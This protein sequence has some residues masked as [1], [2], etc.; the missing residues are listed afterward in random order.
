MNR[1][2]LGLKI[3][4]LGMMGMVITTGGQANDAQR[5]IIPPTYQAVAAK[6]QTPATLLYSIAQLHSGSVLT[7]GHIAPWPWTLAINGR[8]ERYRNQDTAIRA[9][10]R[11]L[12]TKAN[13]QIGLMQLNWSAYQTRFQQH[14][15][16]LLD[17]ALNLTVAAQVLQQHYQRERNWPT[18]AALLDRRVQSARQLKINRSARQRY[19]P[20]IQTIAQRHQLPPLMIEAV[21]AAESNF[22]ARAKSHAGARGLM[23]LMPSTAQRF[24]VRNAYD[25]KQNIEGGT[26]YL[27][28]L[29]DRFKSLP[30]ALAGYNAGEGAVQKYHGAIPPY[31]ETQQYVPKVLAFYRLFLAEATSS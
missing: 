11:H 22:N 20:L 23:Q 3:L 16:R 4:G 15:E 7:T 17:P 29:L 28:W 24:D 2:T 5:W 27:R 21:I 19:T 31:R 1:V 26:R 12:N 6:M 9:L 18:A 14:P 25:P 30:L 13:V 8:V 10:H